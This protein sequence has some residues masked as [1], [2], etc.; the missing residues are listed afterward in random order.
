MYKRQVW[1][2]LRSYL[3]MPKEGPLSDAQTRELKHGYAAS[4][5]FAD[6]QVGKVLG[7]LDQL[8]LRKNTIVV[9]WG[10]HGYKLGEYGAWCKHTNLELDTHVPFI[11]SAPGFV[12]ENALVPSLKW[13]I[14]FLL[15]LS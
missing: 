14:S 9:L 15:W 11:V 4:V 3:G 5:S 8:G 2:E 6:A 13:S 7:E 10:D 12:Q 1:G